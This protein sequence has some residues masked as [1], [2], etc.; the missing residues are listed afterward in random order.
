[1][2]LTGLK[3]FK[4]AGGN[5]YSSIGSSDSS[6]TVGYKQINNLPKFENGTPGQ[7]QSSTSTGNTAMPSVTNISSGPSLTGG[8][9]STASSF[10]PSLGTI[11]NSLTSPNGSQ[12]LDQNSFGGSNYRQP[13]FAPMIDWSSGS[14]RAA[15]IGQV[16]ALTNSISNGNPIDL[17]KSNQILQNSIGSRSTGGGSRSTGGGS[18]STGGKGINVGAIGG[19]ITSTIN[20]AGDAINSFQVNETG[21]EIAQKYGTSQ[22]NVGGIGYESQNMIDLNKEMDRVKKDNLKNTLVTVG[23]GA[24]QREYRRMLAKQNAKIN[25]LQDSARFS[26]QTKAIQQMN[27]REYGNSEA[28]YLYGAKNGMLPKYNNGTPSPNLSNIQK[29]KPGQKLADSTFGK[30]DAFNSYAS[31]GEVAEEDGVIRKLGKGKD[32]NDTLPFFATGKT[33]IFPNKGEEKYGIDISDFV[34]KTGDVNTGLLMLKDYQQN[35]NK[36]SMYAKNGR[37]PRYKGGKITFNPNDLILDDETLTDVKR[38]S[39]R[40]GD[41]FVS[42]L[43]QMKQNANSKTAWTDGWKNTIAPM[44]QADAAVGGLVDPYAINKNLKSPTGTENYGNNDNN[45]VGKWFT[46]PLDNLPYY[47]NMASAL[48]HS[49]FRDRR[50]FTPKTGIAAPQGLDRL[51]ALRMNPYPILINN[52]AAEARTNRAI[53][54]SG[55]L[56]TAQRNLARLAAQYNTQL[57]DAQALANMQIQNNQYISDAVKTRLA[58]ESAYDQRVVAQNN[59][60]DDIFMRGHANNQYMDVDDMTTFGTAWQQANKNRFNGNLYRW[61]MHQYAQENKANRKKKLIS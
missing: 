37:L 53:D 22:Q 46:S 21:D 52:R 55:G 2:E 17:N 12:L 48:G 27:A 8:F 6:K 15:A 44:Y 1:M 5:I 50:I 57:N 24:A 31:N 49:L 36:N 29:I 58:A 9:G 43:A 30:V 32:N 54:M 56:N 47:F 16:G 7:Q 19:A 13:T 4:N 61:M 11:Q 60:R 51:D 23:S 40:R 41:V 10:G 28:Q 35:M 38:A 34:W 26:A 3:S 42:P 33:A 18:R 45:G 20:F 14:Q 39:S 59:L 25:A